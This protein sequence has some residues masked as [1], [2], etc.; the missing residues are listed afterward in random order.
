MRGG[1]HSYPSVR[2]TAWNVTIEKLHQILSCDLFE[3][4]R[5][6]CSTRGTTPIS[7]PRLMGGN[8]SQI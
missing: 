6:F 5:N 4:T 3:I 1:D 7:L 8:T 2:L